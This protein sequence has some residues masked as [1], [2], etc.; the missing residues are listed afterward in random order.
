MGEQLHVF[1]LWSFNIILQLSHGPPS[2]PKKWRV[3]RLTALSS[4]EKK[5]KK[6]HLLSTYFV[7][8][9]V[10][11]ST[12]SYNPVEKRKPLKNDHNLPEADGDRE[13]GGIADGDGASFLTE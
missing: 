5:K 3:L 12:V 2:P 4:R 1:F 6:N 8:G 11:S 13:W 9:R 7:P 10:V